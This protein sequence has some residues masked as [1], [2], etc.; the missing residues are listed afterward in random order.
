MDTR[1]EE[2]PRLAL[3]NNIATRLVKSK[4]AAL[5]R[6]GFNYV[7]SLVLLTLLAILFLFPLYWMFT[8]SFKAQSVT[9][10]VPP[11]L[12]PPN[13]TLENWQHLFAPD[14]PVAR[15]LVNSLIVAGGTTLLTLFVSSLTGYSFG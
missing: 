10:S 3:G 9:I 11:D 5:R 4:T 13:P 14:L 15:W 7:L 8:G 2:H 1:L 12:F 6:A